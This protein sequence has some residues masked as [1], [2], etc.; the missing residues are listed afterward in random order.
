M[1]DIHVEFWLPRGV[2]V[3]ATV[4]ALVAHK[5]QKH[6]LDAIPLVMQE[7]ADV[8]LVDFRRLRAAKAR[9]IGPIDIPE[10]PHDRHVFTVRLGRITEQ[11]IA[12]RFGLQDVTRDPT[13]EVA[14]PERLYRLIE[15]HHH[16]EHVRG[17]ARQLRTM[18][19]NTTRTENRERTIVNRDMPARIVAA[20]AMWLA[21]TAVQLEVE[22][23]GQAERLQRH[24]SEL[25]EILYRDEWLWQVLGP[26]S[27]RRSHGARGERKLP[28]NAPGPRVPRRPRVYARHPAA[29]AGAPRQQP[30]P[31]GSAWLMRGNLLPDRS[32]FGHGGRECR[33]PD[34]NPA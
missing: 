5:G 34:R 14:L 15:T 31:R 12:E 26:G 10:D 18:P 23:P 33:V 24:A 27:D 16:M 17:F 9:K 8:H 21:E 32:G 20:L 3:I 13:H 7:V 28:A 2:P 11:T 6:L 19:T 22:D 4:G 25:L 30:S 1:L 29:V